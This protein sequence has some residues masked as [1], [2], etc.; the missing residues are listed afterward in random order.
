MQHFIQ[1]KLAGSP[2]GDPYER[3]ADHAADAIM[4]MPS[5]FGTIQARCASGGNPGPDGEYSECRK[6]RLGIQRR[7]TSEVTSTGVPPVVNHVPESPGQPLDSTTRDFMESSFGT[8]FRDVLIHTDSPA[9][10]SAKALGA[11]TYTSGRDIYFGAGKYAPSNQEGK[12]LLAHELVHTIQQRANTSPFSSQNAANSDLIIASDDSLEQDADR[13][14]EQ[15]V[16]PAPMGAERE[17]KMHFHRISV[18]KGLVQRKHEHGPVAGVDPHTRLYGNAKRLCSEALPAFQRALDAVAPALV[19]DAGLQILALWTTVDQ[20]N[21]DF[22]PPESIRAPDAPELPVFTEAR[23]AV[24]R[25]VTIQRFRGVDLLGEPRRIDYVADILGHVAAQTQGAGATVTAARQLVRLL[26]NRTRTEEDENAAV[27]ILA[28]HPNPWH[29][30]YL[31]AVLQGEG[32]DPA[33]KTLGLEA[34]RDLQA[35]LL[36][37]DVLKQRQALGPADRIGVVEPLPMERKVRVLRPYGARELAVE[38]YGDS[39]FYDAVLKPYNRSELGE[40]SD[41]ALVPAGTELV[42][43][44][45]LTRGRYHMIFAAVE[46]TKRQADRP[47]IDASP[48]GAV[49]VKTQSTYIVRWPIVEPSANAFQI[50]GMPTL[51]LPKSQQSDWVALT[52]YVENDPGPGKQRGPDYDVMVGFDEF[53]TERLTAEG[54]KMERTWDDVGTPTV[55]AELVFHGWLYMP[56]VTLRYPQPVVTDREKLEADWPTVDD[57]RLDLSTLLGT[58]AETYGDFKRIADD[59]GVTQDELAHDPKLAMQV[60]TAYYPEFLVRDLRQQQKGTANAHRKRELGYQID[61]IEQAIDETKRWSMRPV[62]ALYV[63]SDDDKTQSAPLTLYIAPDPEAPA[64]F[65]YALKL[66]DFTREGAGRAFTDGH[67]ATN[68]ELAVR[69]L[70]DE[71]GDMAPY[72]KGTVRFVIDSAL[73]PEDFAGKYPLARGIYEV[74]TRGGSRLE[75]FSGAIVTGLVVIGASAIVGPEAALTAFAIYG[76]IMGFEDIV[77]RLADGSFEWDLQTGLDILAIAGGLAAGISPVITAVRGVG[78]VAW[79]GTAAKAA[80]SSSSA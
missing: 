31:R 68:P 39:V 7:T 12:Q 76:A 71:F 8:D 75:K 48:A 65:P 30:A 62:K 40:I 43:E 56:A 28:N 11:N 64:A 32:L 37:Q 70:F 13:V 27:R 14:A 24:L 38:L 59:L 58:R 52:W 17:L 67:G 4:W 21:R 20:A 41:I 9:A 63:S 60:S 36:S 79:L 51:W 74:H 35:V 49:I 54:A 3:E 46:M 5:P 78:A 80:A 10:A 22:Q 15:I 25:G 47:Y 42:V 69:G 57:P 33:L 50:Q 23:E 6:N 61:S 45:G 16:S 66:W 2:P 55:R 26:G 18:R 19:A 44:P 72:P 73:L 77:Q 34:A 53:G 29:F 1:A